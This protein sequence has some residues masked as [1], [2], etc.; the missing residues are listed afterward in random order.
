MRISRIFAAFA[1]ITAL[2]AGVAWST[3]VPTETADTAAPITSDGSTTLLSADSTSDA[4]DSTR[5]FPPC[6]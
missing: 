3:V 6:C 1:L 2:A 5:G 4:T